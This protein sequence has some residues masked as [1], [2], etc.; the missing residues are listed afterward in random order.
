VQR[1]FVANRS[2]IAARICR[3]ARGEGIASVVAWSSDDADA[4]WLRLADET[5]ALPGEGP[6]AHLDVDAVIAAAQRTRCDALHPGYGLLSERHELAAA[7]EAA[8]IVFVGPTADALRTLG[9]K[10]EARELANWHNVPVVSG[11]AL[12]PS[13]DDALAL[14]EAIRAATGS[15]SVMIKAVAGGGG[16][17]MRIVTGTGKKRTDKPAITRAMNECRSEA[18]SAFGVGDLIVEEALPMVRHIE[19]Q[20]LG[21]GQSVVDLGERDCSLQRRRQKILEIAPAPGMTDGLRERLG[22]AATTLAGAVSY[23]SAGTLE[24]L[25]DAT[26]GALHD[27]TP[28]WFIEANPRLQVEHT[29][30]EEITGIDIVAT[31]LRIAA[32]ATLAELG[33][34]ERPPLRG[35][36]LQARVNAETYTVD[37]SVK[38]SGGT[39]RALTIPAG[40]GVRVDTGLAAGAKVNPRFDSLMAKVI[41]HSPDHAS[42]ARRLRGALQEW[43]SPGV[44]TNASVLGALAEDFLVDGI[45]I[46][47]TT[48]LDERLPTLV[49]I[50]TEGAADM[51]E[52]VSPG[53]HTHP[54]A[55]IAIAIGEGHTAV[56]AA[57]AGTV[58][59]IT[60]RVGDEVAAGQEV[61][62]LEAMKMQHGVTT[63]C[64]GRITSV[65]V[66]VGDV[67]AEGQPLVAVMPDAAADTASASVA[68]SVDPAHIRPDLASVMR[69]HEIGLDASRTDAVARRHGRGHR[70][71]RENI[72]DLVDA[73]SFVEFGPLAIAAQRKRRSLD[74]LIANTPA[75]GLVGGLASVNGELF[76]DDDTTTRCIVASYDYMVLAGTQGSLNHRKK[77]RLFELAE[78]WKL[79]I[80]LF[81]E[82]G[83]GRPGDT[84]QL[85]VSGLDCLAFWYFAKLSG[86]V[87]LIGIANG[88]CFAGNAALLGCCDVII[89]T[90]GSSIGMGGP[91]MIEGGGLGVHDP[92]TVGPMSVQVPNGVVDIA[93]V[94]EAAAVAVAKQY[95]S[96]FQGPTT[97]W[98]CADQ[99][100]LRY[101]VP[102]N[103]LRAYDIRDAIDLLADTG[104]VLELRPQFGKGMITAL[105]RIEGRPIGIVANDPRF[106]GG[107]IA[108]EEADKAAR[109]MQIC[110]AYG[111]PLL[112]LCDTPGFMVGPDAERHALVRHVSRMFVTAASVTVP[113]FTVVTRKGYGLGAQGMAGGSFQAP[114][115]IVGWPTSE[116]GGM[117][118]EGAVRLG[119]RK[120][121]DAIA[122][123][124]E[125]AATEAQ[126]IARMYEIGKGENTA[127]FLEID[128]VIDPADTRRWIMAAL[129]SVPPMAG[130]RSEPEKR[131]PNIDTW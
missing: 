102:E 21:D 121:L 15:G 105:V 28:F 42:A 40:P 48:D 94:D 54:A 65:L 101:V 35:A 12:N 110:D 45:G 100:L 55:P 96:Y 97:E 16:R 116:F 17:G 69:R 106:L 20:V 125:R 34:T 90:E 131:R 9:D 109:F 71:A 80:V 37:G 24:F 23:R 123:P 22:W 11:T 52:P 95:L 68:V 43:S 73:D 93:V 62:V 83:G 124:V 13:V 18:V 107:A 61:A 127:S 5:V 49:A 111:L 36:S 14:L 82:G 81:A 86:L 115:F 128:D 2:E 32:G 51:H 63:A 46:L 56:T 3:A 29:I 126:M 67:V 89:A 120:E 117:G 7:C 25:V 108:H 129:R 98:E 57:L 30:T 78:R 122:D 27:E 33:L 1:L 130:W 31:Q 53:T 119:Y 85:G 26:G 59:S 39:I 47:S 88:Y 4:P 75:D 103:R 66:D 114:G 87:P 76:G 77:D 74:D 118:L 64:A 19:V 104:S 10:H 44:A 70:T 113:F 112:F 84:D 92:K 91:A 38:P 41:V 6:A 60:A 79:P 8:G 58:V 99:R 72:A 50:A